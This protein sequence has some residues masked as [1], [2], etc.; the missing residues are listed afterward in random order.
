MLT[1]GLIAPGGLA[2]LMAGTDTTSVTSPARA[3]A[4]VL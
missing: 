1:L 2:I 4:W 3:S